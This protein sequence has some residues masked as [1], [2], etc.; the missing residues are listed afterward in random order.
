VPHFTNVRVYSRLF[1]NPKAE[2]PLT[3][4][5]AETLLSVFDRR[6]VLD[7][8]V[9]RTRKLL[10]ERYRPDGIILFGSLADPVPDHVHQWSDIDLF[11]VKPTRQRFAQR[12]KEVVALTESRVAVNVI[13]Y[14]PEELARA[15]QE[16]GF[17]IRDEI[18]GRGRVLYP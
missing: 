12:G 7:R 4:P 10:V 5:V 2:R 9:E 17:F 3:A 13:V 8:E 18:L 11:V 15:E 16:G 6:A 1:I 14:T